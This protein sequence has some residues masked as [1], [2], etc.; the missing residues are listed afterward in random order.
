[1]GG[2]GRLTIGGLFANKICGA[3]IPEGLLSE[4]YANRGFAGQ[5]CG[6]LKCVSVRMFSASVYAG[7]LIKKKKVA[8]GYSILRRFSKKC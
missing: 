3:Y 5:F 6:R 1:M 7:T 4:F 2:G 8:Y